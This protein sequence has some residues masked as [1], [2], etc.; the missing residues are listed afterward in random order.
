M[1]GIPNEVAIWGSHYLFSPSGQPPLLA[2]VPPPSCPSQPASAS[3]P[4]RQLVTNIYPSPSVTL[5]TGVVSMT[6]M[7]SV[8]SSMSIPTS[9]SSPHIKISIASAIHSQPQTHA[10]LQSKQENITMKMES[11]KGQET[12][13]QREVM[14]NTANQATRSDVAGSTQSSSPTSH[15]H[16][17]KLILI[18]T[19]HVY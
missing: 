9:P 13:T 5:A 17:G 4:T 16:P 7:P 12:E 1:V 15:S 14:S 2:P 10:D 3:G 8:T 11:P 6:T 19:A 18:Q